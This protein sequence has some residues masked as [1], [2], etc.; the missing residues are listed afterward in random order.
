V[1]TELKGFVQLQPAEAGLH[2]VGWLNRNVDEDLFAECAEKTGLD[3]PLLSTFGKTALVRPGVVFGFAPF[4]EIKIR[5]SISA[6]GKALRSAQKARVRQKRKERA[7]AEEP[8]GFF[9]RLFAAH[10]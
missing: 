10:H 9:R 4:S 2:A 8:V 5:Q 7:S 1:G 6:L 3:V